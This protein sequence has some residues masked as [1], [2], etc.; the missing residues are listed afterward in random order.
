V[1]TT[2]E[3]LAANERHN[4][5]RAAVSALAAEWQR[6]ADEHM[7]RFGQHLPCSVER[8]AELL[9]ALLDDQETNR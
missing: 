9:R 3:L 8:M 4:K 1:S 7:V 5:L 2:T 6:D